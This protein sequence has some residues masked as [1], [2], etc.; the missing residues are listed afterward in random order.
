MAAVRRVTPKP[1]MTL[2]APVTAPEVAPAR[3][4]P[5]GQPV[6]PAEPRARPAAAAWRDAEPLWALPGVAS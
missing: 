1:P 2:R 5:L 4:V 6:V 3:V